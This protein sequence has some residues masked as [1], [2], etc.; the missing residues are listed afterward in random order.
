MKI[1][2]NLCSLILFFLPQK[3]QKKEAYFKLIKDEK[4]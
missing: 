3:S 2:Y 4:S 1:S